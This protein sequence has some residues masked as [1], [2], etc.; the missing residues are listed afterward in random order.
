MG[1]ADFFSNLFDTNGFP[2]RW[3]CGSAWT[4]ELGYTHII[5]DLVIFA[6]YISIPIS[7]FF[8]SR[9]QPIIKNKYLATLFIL[10][11][12]L[13]GIGHLVEAS[14]FYEPWYRFS[15]LLKV[16]IATA[17]LATATILALNLKKFLTIPQSIEFRKSIEFL[18]EKLPNPFLI[19]DDNGTIISV[20]TK[21]LSYSGYSLSDLLGKSYRQLFPSYNTKQAEKIIT[22]IL[23]N[24]DRPVET[25]NLRTKKK[26]IRKT[27]ISVTFLR[28]SESKE[29]LISVTD[30]DQKFELERTTKK[31]NAI[32]NSVVDGI[33]TINNKGEIQSFNPAAERIFGYKENE[34]M[35]MNLKML[36]PASYQKHHDQY[37]QNYIS[38]GMAKVI[39]IGREVTAVRKDGRQFPMD[40]GISDVKVNNEQIF[41]GVIRDISDRKETELALTTY[42]KKME[43]ANEQLKIANDE[44]KQANAAKSDFL[45]SMSH[46]LRTPMHAILSYSN[47]GQDSLSDDN[48]DD[49]QDC[50]Q[51]ISIAGNRLLGLLNN[52][53][54]LAKLESGKMEFI[55]DSQNVSETIN[56]AI[57][58]LNSLLSIK[59]M[60][61]VT[62][63]DPSIPT[64]LFDRQ[65]ILQVLINLLSNSIKFSPNDSTVTLSTSCK[66]SN[67]IISVQ[68]QGVGIPESEL[69]SIFDK[70]TQSSHTDTK[71]G[72]TGLGLAIS[73]EIILAHNGSIRAYNAPEGGAVFEFSIPIKEEKLTLN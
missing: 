28:L 40:L 63:L 32:F 45:S 43:T 64:A 60:K 44:A 24:Q 15:A 34:V 14:L 30:I 17:S 4:P 37:I 9:K 21:L 5:S 7:I 48:K 35:G 20:N 12:A 26:E 41:V 73:K 18:I 2:P 33:I 66:N 36:M 25:V 13:C 38:T 31:M 52:L 46:E 1:L 57:S 67:L 50:F 39:G 8:A 61:C 49:I 62:Q 10:F 54:D 69:E 71:A 53:L 16:L 58:E 3:F 65:K 68:D 27:E 29:F 42:A 19:V 47:L 11:I 51:N 70:F 59:D 72:G 55:F 22:R 23:K 56:Q 6:S